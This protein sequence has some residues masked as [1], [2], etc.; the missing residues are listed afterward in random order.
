MVVQLFQL[1]MIVFSINK[2]ERK[3][4]QSILYLSKKCFMSSPRLLDAALQRLY[5]VP[6]EHKL[7]NLELEGHIC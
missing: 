4:A 6:H 2:N 7:V 5:L 3:G 1:F